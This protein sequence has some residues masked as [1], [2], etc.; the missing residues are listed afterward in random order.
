MEMFKD[1]PRLKSI[2]CGR[3]RYTNSYGTNVKCRGTVVLKPSLSKDYLAGKCDKC[4][5]MHTEYRG[6]LGP[7]PQIKPTNAVEESGNGL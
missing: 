3:I 6:L 7:Q 4:L 5:W 2:E 1:V